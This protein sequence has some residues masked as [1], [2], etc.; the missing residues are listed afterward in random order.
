MKL[1]SEVHT[2]SWNLLQSVPPN[3]IWKKKVNFSFETCRSTLSI[4]P[5][6]C[7][8]LDLL[9]AS[10]QAGA[11]W[12]RKKKST[13][14]HNS[15]G[16]PPSQIINHFNF[17]RVALF[18][19][20]IIRLFQFVFSAGIIFFLSQQISQQCFSAGLSAQPNGSSIFKRLSIYFL[21]ECLLVETLVKNYPLT[22]SQV[23]IQI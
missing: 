9:L 15:I 3:N 7:Y 17:L 19:R 11:S 16:L 13:I 22:A 18:I 10:H 4:I 12:G 6:K 20:L 23:I 2:R 5:H 8:G 21:P 14:D 1:S